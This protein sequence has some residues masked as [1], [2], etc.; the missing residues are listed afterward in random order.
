MQQGRAVLLKKLN[1]AERVCSNSGSI[2]FRHSIG[3][4]NGSPLLL[5]VISFYLIGPAIQFSGEPGKISFQHV[6][7]P[8]V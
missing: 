6:N 8:Y 1:A 5:S 7:R 3:V 4:A 2:S